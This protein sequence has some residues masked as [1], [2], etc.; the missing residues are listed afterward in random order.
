[1]ARPTD[2]PRMPDSASGVSKT[3][4]APK[5]CC[6]PSVMRKTPPSWPTSSPST[7]ARGFSASTSARAA[8]MALF[9]D[10]VSLPVRG[11]VSMAS[12]LVGACPV[13]SMVAFRLDMLGLLPPLRGLLL[14][15]LGL[16]LVDV[17]EHLGARARALGLDGQPSRFL[18]L[19]GL[20]LDGVDAGRVERTVG[21]QAFSQ[22]LD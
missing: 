10:S 20:G 6:S 11:T 16:L 12:S 7:R 18:E 4:S 13:D 1:M 8:L 3:R 22:G 15:G 17:L 9:I 5:R 2:M 21:Q 19:G 14:Q